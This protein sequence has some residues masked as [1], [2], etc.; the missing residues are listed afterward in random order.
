MYGI[1]V[2]VYISVTSR[3]EGPDSNP[4]PGSSPDPADS[5]S[6]RVK[7][8]TNDFKIDTCCL[9]L[10]IIRIGQGLVCSVSRLVHVAIENANATL[11]HPS[12]AVLKPVYGA[13]SLAR[14]KGGYGLVGLFVCCC[15]TS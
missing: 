15:F 1:L 14:L 10:G 7:R 3:L 13:S 9:V 2:C 12:P 11:T 5:I 6:D 4:D 8:Q